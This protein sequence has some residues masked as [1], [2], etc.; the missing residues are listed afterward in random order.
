MVVSRLLQKN[1]L[2]HTDLQNCK[3]I[4]PPLSQVTSMKNFKVNCTFGI[5]DSDLKDVI[6]KSICKSNQ[7]FPSLTTILTISKEKLVDLNVWDNCIILSGMHR[8]KHQVIYMKTSYGKIINRHDLSQPI[9]LHSLCNN[10]IVMVSDLDDW[11][12]DGVLH[13]NIIPISLSNGLG[14]DDYVINMI[15][16]N[17]ENNHLEGWTDSLVADI[18]TVM[19]VSV[20]NRYKTV[21]H[22]SIGMYLGFGWTAKYDRHREAGVTY[23]TFSPKKGICMKTL[24]HC[25]D[26]LV[27]NL[28]QFAD[29]LNKVIPDILKGGQAIL[30]ALVKISQQLCKDLPSNII[31]ELSQGIL[32][33]Y[34]C[35]NAQTIMV[36]LEQDCAYTLIAVPL[37]MHDM[38]RKSKFVFEFYSDWGSG[39]QIDLKP[40]TSIYYNG[41]SLIHRKISL[42]DLGEQKH[43]YNFWNLSSYGNKHLYDNCVASFKHV[44]H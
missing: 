4:K 7:K 1:N 16:S 20:D 30:L 13:G 25:K 43:D 10:C 3:C 5:D 32:C 23:G 15:A 2:R 40:G 36:H 11:F 18:S 28:D 44:C 42:L 35:K 12:L 17:K 31:Q 21:H 14:I 9:D 37:G 39:V 8:D 6:W 19:N 41:Y 38:N 33:A 22:G 27:N 29:E 26:F 34:V 24:G